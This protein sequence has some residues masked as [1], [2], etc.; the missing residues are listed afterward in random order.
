[1]AQAEVLIDVVAVLE[2]EGGRLGVGE[3][4]ELIDGELHLTGGQVGVEVLGSAPGHQAPGRDHVL[5]AQPVGELVRRG[6]GI[7]VKDEL[8][9]PG[10]IAEIDE[11]ETAVVA[12]PV[13][14][15]RHPGSGAGP[16]AGELLA[17]GV[18]E[19]VGPRCLLHDSRLERRMVGMIS[20]GESSRCSPDSI[21]R[22]LAS[23]SPATMATNR[24]WM[25]SAW[26]S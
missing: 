17:P 14:P 26:R 22:R 2:R 13:H 10:A 3:D 15:P 8:E 18:A 4:L 23:A 21:S 20:V 7:G 24:A 11:D 5:G 25:R 9:D 12:A 1:M 19:G 6:P 16:L